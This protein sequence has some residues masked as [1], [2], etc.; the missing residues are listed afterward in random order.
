MALYAAVRPRTGRRRARRRRRG[1]PRISPAAAG[2]R[3]ANL[4]L[5]D[6]APAAPVLGELPDGVIVAELGQALIDHEELVRSRLYRLIGFDDRPGALNAATWE[7]GTFVY[8][9]RGVE[10][11]L[12]TETLLTAT[13]ARG[14]VSARTLVIVDEGAKATVIDRYRSGA[15]A[16]PVDR[17]DG[18]RD[19]R[20]RRRRA[21][22]PVADRVGRRRPPPRPRHRVGRQGRAR[23]LRRRHPRRRRRPGRGHAHRRRPRFGL[24]CARA[25]LRR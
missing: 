24:A 1:A 7:G 20:R 25:L 23:A 15:L 18:H 5:A 4:A 19:H 11:A 10:L 13:G 14:R 8:V 2:P 21:R 22:A 3:S 6:G 12:P 16:S 17:L 9:P